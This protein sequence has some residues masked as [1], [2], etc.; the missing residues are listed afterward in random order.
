MSKSRLAAALVVV[1]LGTVGCAGREPP[2]RYSADAPDTAAVRGQRLAV[3]AC[4]GCHA[5]G[6]VGASPLAAA[7]P[8]RDIVQRRSLD[9]LEEGFASGL[10]TSH[11]AMPPFNFRASEI[12]DLIAYLETL[13]ADA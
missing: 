2:V 6:S 5:V 8:F 1:T 13:K 4:G 11:P 7:T 3:Q 10:V 9:R 12:D